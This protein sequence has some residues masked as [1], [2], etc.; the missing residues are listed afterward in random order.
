[1]GA[2]GRREAIRDLEERTDVLDVPEEHWPLFVRFRDLQD[3]GSIE[4]VTSETAA[5]LLG[6]DASIER[7]TMQTVREP[8]T[9]R[10]ETVLPWLRGLRTNLAGAPVR[11]AQGGWV[12]RLSVTN[13]RKWNVDF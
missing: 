11:Q 2:D 3:P 7:L 8:A 5:S 6:G 10:I 9:E 4:E 12:D 1:M 13:F